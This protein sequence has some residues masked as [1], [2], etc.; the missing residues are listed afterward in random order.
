MSETCQ[1]AVMLDSIRSRI[2]DGTLLPP[3]Y[4]ESLECD[5]VLDA[6]D[7]TDGFVSRWSR[8]HEQVGDRWAAVR[9]PDHLRTQAEDIRR[10][11]FLVVSRATGQ[12]EVASYVS[13][14]LD[15]IVRA[16]LVGLTDPL[17]DHLWQSYDQGEFPGPMKLP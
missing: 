13:D 6:R 10:D 7:R 3:G 9:V 15:L 17:L 12:H 11:A 5:S 4:Y 2:A 16:G 8:L 14:D 1:G